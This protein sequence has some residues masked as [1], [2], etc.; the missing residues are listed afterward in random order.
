MSMSRFVLP[1]PWLHPMIAPPT[2]LA[3][4]HPR[5]PACFWSNSSAAGSCG[6]DRRRAPGRVRAQRLVTRSAATDP[7]HAQR[8]RAMEFRIAKTESS[9][10][11]SSRLQRG[12]QVGRGPAADI[13]P[14]RPP[15]SRPPTW[16]TP[17]SSAA[18]RGPSG[19]RRRHADHRARVPRRP[20][21]VPRQ[22]RQR[23]HA[24]RRASGPRRRGR[25]ARPRP[26]RHSIANT[27]RLSAG[28][29]LTAPR[30]GCA[31]SRHGPTHR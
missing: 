9:A 2:A 25:R 7:P 11:A 22:P 18:T 28:R 30:H 15:S 21:R 24:E 19:R 12:H 20:P 4:R 17:A 27:N 13:A 1:D 31:E 8:L 10:R 26:I 6:G 16:S 23:R 29:W 5:L 3:P 14:Q